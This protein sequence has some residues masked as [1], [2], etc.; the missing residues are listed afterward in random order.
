[1]LIVLRH[2][3]IRLSTGLILRCGEQWI[4]YIES[5]NFELTSIFRY[6]YRNG[7]IVL[8]S[9][10]LL[11]LILGIAY[12]V[13][14]RRSG[15]SSKKRKKSS[16]SPVVYE[17]FAPLGESNTQNE[18]YTSLATIVDENEKRRPRYMTAVFDKPNDVEYTL[19]G[20]KEIQPA[21]V[22][23]EVLAPDADNNNNNNNNSNDNGNDDDDD[24]DDHVDVDERPAYTSLNAV[25]QLK[26]IE[27]G[28]EA[29]H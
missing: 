3:S 26:Y 14:A 20:D 29:E 23:Y 15:N 7:R 2:C 16:S 22:Q 5:S 9:L 18:Q 13:F 17:Q 21:P 11:A 24:D 19:L 28:E 6:V 25:K 10:V 27:L 1:V 12:C 8:V 4:V